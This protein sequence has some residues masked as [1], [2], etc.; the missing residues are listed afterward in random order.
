MWVIRE[1]IRFEEQRGL[2]HQQE[3]EAEMLEHAENLEFEEAAALRDEIQS[4][5]ADHLLR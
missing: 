5:R 2:P 4:L 1:A 3:L